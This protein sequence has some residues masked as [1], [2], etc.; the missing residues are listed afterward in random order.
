MT[1]FEK[2]TIIIKEKISNTAPRGSNPLPSTCDA[3]AD[4]YEL[5]ERQNFKRTYKELI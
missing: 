4:S 5:L 2:E 3:E 1:G